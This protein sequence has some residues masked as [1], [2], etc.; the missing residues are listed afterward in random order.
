MCVLSIA[1]SGSLHAAKL[2]TRSVYCVDQGSETWSLQR[3]QPLINPRGKTHFVQLSFSGATLE[4]ARLRRFYPEYEVSFEYRYD[5]QGRLTGLKGSVEFWNRWI[6]S[7]DLYPEED[8]SIPQRRVRFISPRGGEEVA[9]P[10]EWQ[11]F[12][13][14]LRDVK[15]YRTIDSLPC[16]GRLQ[17][18]EKMNATQE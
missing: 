13:P 11:D 17:E 15:V 1:L 7:A 4:A 3:Y 14:L 10:E 6:G 18:V 12:D 2:K 16:G 5:S 9:R 8:G